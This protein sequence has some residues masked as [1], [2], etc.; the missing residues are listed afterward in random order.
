MDRKRITDYLKVLWEQE[1]PRKPTAEMETS[2]RHFSEKAFKRKAPPLYRRWYVVSPAAAAVLILLI[3]MFNN[4][5]NKPAGGESG[6]MIAQNSGGRVKTL[7]LPDSTVVR[8]QPKST[9]YYAKNFGEKR[10]VK[11]IGE[12]FFDVTRNEATP[13][14]LAGLNTMT[15]VLGTS[16]HIEALPEKGVMLQLYEGSVKMEVEGLE[17]SWEL[18]PG[19][20]FDYIGGEVDIDLFTTYIDFENTTLGKVME[21]ILDTY[22]YTVA[23]DQTLLGK[24]VTLRVSKSDHLS[25]II[26]TIA[27]IYGLNIQTDEG[28]KQI[29]LSE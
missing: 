4:I 24:T 22:G 18:A 9:L 27:A 26:E 14:T 17:G 2:W 11:L 16:F 5:G 15:T 29:T 19:Q 6:Y 12:A 21:Y 25:D 13:F 7:Y 20:Q 10:S 3:F 28:L 23:A 8:L 1:Y